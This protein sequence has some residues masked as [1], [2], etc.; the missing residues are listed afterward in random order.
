ML[1]SRQTKT[2]KT[3]PPE[4]HFRAHDTRDFCDFLVLSATGGHLNDLCALKK[5]RRQGSITRPI[6]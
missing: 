2:G 5:R 4:L 3:L 6:G 1:E